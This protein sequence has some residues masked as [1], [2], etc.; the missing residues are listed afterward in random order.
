MLL[1]IPNFL[2]FL[3]L[4]SLPLS[5]LFWR[6]NQ[7]FLSAIIFFSGMLTDSIDGWIAR[8]MNQTSLIGTY[9]DPIVDKVVILCWLYELALSSIINI[10]LA[11]L[12][13]VRELI[14]DGIR[15]FAAIRGNVVG[16]NAMGK[17]KAFLQ[18]IIILWGILSGT[19]SRI[20]PSPIANLL[21]L[22]FPYFTCAV[23]LLS[24]IFTAEFIR[25]N[26]QIFK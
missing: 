14:H 2:T 23:L 7:S 15:G 25:R 11:H 9:L 26:R 21:N 12:F 6:H 20:L 1:T 10:N 5:V 24:Y 19:F 13:L 16:A 3:R 8:K 22:I 17:T 18:V 4:G